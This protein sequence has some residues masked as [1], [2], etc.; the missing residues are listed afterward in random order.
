MRTPTLTKSCGSDLAKTQQRLN[1]GRE[2]LCS[3]GLWF[4]AGMGPVRCDVSLLFKYR[5]HARLQ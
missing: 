1:S 4:S 2:Q 5:E 3:A